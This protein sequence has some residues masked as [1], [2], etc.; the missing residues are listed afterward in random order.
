MRVDLR[1]RLYEW[2]CREILGRADQDVGFWLGIAR[3]APPEAPG[4]LEL[5]CGTGR[6]TLPLA[7][8][9]CEMVGLDI[10]VGALEVARERRGGA[11][12]PLLV[13]ADMRRFTLHRRFGAVV[14]PYNSFQLL[15]QPADAASCLRTVVDHL[16]PGGTFAL[17]VTDFQAGAER[18]EVAEE[19]LGT[20]ELDGAA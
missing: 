4:V 6:V 11:Q 13:A 17:E 20:G 19:V 15:V 16:A 1:A 7:A 5:A 18:A 9:G 10:D 14:I 12:W 3:S 8:A 2:E